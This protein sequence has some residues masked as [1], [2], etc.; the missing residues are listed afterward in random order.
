MV[1]ASAIAVPARQGA[2]ALATGGIR[3][4]EEIRGL[5]PLRGAVRLDIPL[6]QDDSRL[7]HILHGAASSEMSP[8]LCKG[9]REAN[10]V[11]NDESSFT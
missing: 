5:M 4:R 7:G 6:S 8:V 9:A 3:D 2:Y 10:S 11:Q 1:V